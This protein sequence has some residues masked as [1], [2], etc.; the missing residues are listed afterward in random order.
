MPE[1]NTHSTS[2]GT[3]DV[4]PIPL[5]ET[6]S[7][8]L[9]FYPI[10]V[11]AS[12]N[13]LRGGFR[14]EK[15]GRNETWEEFE[16]RSITTLHRD[17]AYELNLSGED[18]ATLFSNLE[19]IKALL[20]QWGHRY[21]D[22]TF[23]LADNNA[24]G[25]LLQIS[26]GA[27]RDLIIGKLRELEANNFRSIENAVATAKLQTAI[28][29]IRENLGNRVESFWQ[30]YF[31]NNS[32]IIQQIFHFPLYYMQGETYVGGKNTRGRNGQGGVA[33]DQLFLNGANGSFAVVEI[34]PP[35]TPLVGGQYRGDDEGRE[36]ICYS[37]SAQLTGS[38]V[39]MEN[40]IR[41]AVN[42]FQTML[43][44]TFLT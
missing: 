18:M 14:F 38:L 42:D 7:T 23:S 8:R 40:Q 19:R 17:E 2:A 21:G 34:K 26:D 41:V 37:M 33:T 31:D 32:W 30:D 10:W 4:S 43:G 11:D 12:D 35:T 1:I 24:E 20:E 25:I 15:K 9:F 27:N 22:T 13:H 29:F 39:Q 6:G 16:G 5:H 28:D 3:M 44:R 36:N